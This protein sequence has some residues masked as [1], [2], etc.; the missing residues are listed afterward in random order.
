MWPWQ[1]YSSPS[2]LVSTRSKM[3]LA[4]YLMRSMGRVGG[5]MDAMPPLPAAA[6]CVCT[7][8][9]LVSP[10]RSAYLHAC[11]G[12]LAAG[13]CRRDKVASAGG[14]N[15]ALRWSHAPA[16]RTQRSHASPWT[17]RDQVRQALRSRAAADRAA[18]CLKA[19]M[20]C[21]GGSM[22]RRNVPK[23]SGLRTALHPFEPQPPIS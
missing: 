8:P 4:W 19:P 9:C 17:S 6:A 3:S 21:Q 10:C 11:M 16:H 2:E 20:R 18:A 22:H 12:D 1:G 23:S 13:A 5:I 7:R 15:R 14:G